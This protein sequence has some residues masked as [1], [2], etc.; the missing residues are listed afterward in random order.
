MLD[1]VSFGTT[2]YIEAVAFYQQVLAPLG[3]ELLRDT[4]REAAFG[5][6]ER[7][8]FFLYPVDPGEPVDGAGTHLAIAAPSRDGVRG[9]HAAA[10]QAA[11]TDLWSPRERPDID[12]LYYG[13]MFRDL[14]GH[15]IE[16]MT[17]IV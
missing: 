13:A 1:H 2:R 16:V 4:G 9:A 15:R 11:G 14:D 10:L 12:D 3:Y 17:R 7:W 5:T 8:C 6:P